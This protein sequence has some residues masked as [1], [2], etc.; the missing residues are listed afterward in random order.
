VSHQRTIDEIRQRAAG[1][2]GQYGGDV[3]FLLD[4][5]EGA[6]AA[7]RWRDALAEEWSAH[8]RALAQE[9]GRL[10]RLLLRVTTLRHPSLDGGLGRDIAASLA[11]PPPAEHTYAR[12][13]EA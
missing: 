3:A 13:P 12:E 6:L 4:A 10:R 8:M 11:T 9:N 1:S 2:V 5:L 7:I